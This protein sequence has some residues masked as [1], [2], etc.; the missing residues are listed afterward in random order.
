LRISFARRNSRFS[1]RSRRSS[2]DSSLV[3]PGRVPASTSARRTYLR[4]VA[5]EPMPSLVA[6]E[7]IA[8]RKPTTAVLRP[9]DAQRDGEGAEA[10][11]ADVVHTFVMGAAS[12]ARPRGS[13]PYI[14]STVRSTL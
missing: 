9:P 10:R 7:R 2:A 12:A 14:S 8:S 4:T 6:T 11:A 1:A 5:V 13:R 3:T